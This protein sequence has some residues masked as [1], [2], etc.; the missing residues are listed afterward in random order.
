M[1]LKDKIKDFW[2]KKPCGTLGTIP[3]KIDLEYFL[4]IKERRYKLEPFI[5]KIAQFEKWRNKRVLEIGC[6]IGIDGLEF[7]KNGAD[8][9]GIDISEKSLELAKTYFSLNGQKGHLLLSDSEN[10]PF[11]DNTF[12]LVYSWG[13]L[14]HTPDTQKAINE[15]YRVLK[16]RG[17]AII[18]LYNRHSLVALQLYIIYGLLKLR[19][20]ISFQK[21]FSEHHESPGTKAF[22]N[23]EIKS[24]FKEFRNVEIKNILTPYDFRI[25]KNTYLPIWFRKFFSSRLGFFTAI[26]ASK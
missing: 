15:I 24:M 12:D 23:K 13:V 10:L 19:P 26:N 17:Q 25:R 5:K 11:E 22:S 7:V 9:I 21:L 2:N 8:Y 6:G 1:Y 20:F 16:P 14:H 18:M 4:K 3:E